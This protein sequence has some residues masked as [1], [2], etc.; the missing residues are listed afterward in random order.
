MC[1]QADVFMSRGSLRFI[2]LVVRR[3]KDNFSIG[4]KTNTKFIYLG[5]TIQR[6][7]D[8]VVSMDQISCINSDDW[9][10]LDS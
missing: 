7:Q 2:K 5:L 3:I 9:I 1:T 8:H 4:I 10:K 6:F